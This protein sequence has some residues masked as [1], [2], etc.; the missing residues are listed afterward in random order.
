M[1]FEYLYLII[2][3]FGN[4]GPSGQGPRRQLLINRPVKSVIRAMAVVFIMIRRKDVYG[5]FT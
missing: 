1:V 5:S 2:I 3:F 4:G